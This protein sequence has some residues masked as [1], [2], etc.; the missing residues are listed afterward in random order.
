MDVVPL[1]ASLVK[2]SHGRPTDNADDG[3]LLISSERRLIPD[4]PVAATAVRDIV[5][6]HVFD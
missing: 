3:P 5:L 1:D 2:G 6:A 4:A